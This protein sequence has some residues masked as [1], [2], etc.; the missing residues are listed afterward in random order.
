M[1]KARLTTRNLVLGNVISSSTVY[2]TDYVICRSMKD[3]S[4]EVKCS[5]PSALTT[6][7]S[8]KEVKITNL[9]GL[10]DYNI[11]LDLH[12]DHDYAVAGDFLPK[13]QGRMIH[14][15][16]SVN[17]KL[18]RNEVTEYDLMS[19]RL[20]SGNAVEAVIPAASCFQLTLRESMTTLQIPFMVDGKFKLE[21]D[22]VFSELDAS[23]SGVITSNVLDADYSEVLPCN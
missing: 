7:K 14:L 10:E 13:S 17:F 21:K 1:N 19:V 2:N 4:A 12:I 18:F 5:L 3:T 8:I 16:G 15:E 22:M 11:D 6:F 9:S 20:P 23:L